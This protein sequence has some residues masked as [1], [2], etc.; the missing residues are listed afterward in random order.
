MMSVLTGTA[1]YP[2][3]PATARQTPDGWK[4]SRLVLDLFCGEAKTDAAGYLDLVGGRGP[5]ASSQR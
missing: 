3:T 4:I 1:A 5:G 2:I